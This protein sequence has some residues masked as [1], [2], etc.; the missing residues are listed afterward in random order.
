MSKTMKRLFLSLI[1]VVFALALALGACGGGKP[2]LTFETGDGTP[3]EPIVAE[4][5][6]D[7]TALLPPD[8]TCDGFV[9]D[10]W[11]LDA[12]CT[13]ATDLPTT[14]PEKSTKYYAKWRDASLKQLTVSVGNG[15]TTEGE[16]SYY[17]AAGSNL[18]TFL[19]DKQ[20]TPKTGLE[21]AG[22]YIG[23]TAVTQET[24]MPSTTTTVTA[25]YNATYSLNVYE[26]KADGT[27]PAESVTSEGKGIYGEP[28][29]YAAPEH[30]TLDQTQGTFASDSLGTK[31]SFTVYLARETYLVIYNVNIPESTAHIAS[32]TVYYEGSVTLADG[33]DFNLPNN[34]YFLGWA[35]TAEGNVT[36][37]AG[38]QITNVTDDIRL[39][40]VWNVG[41]A[42]LFGGDDVIFLDGDTVTLHRGGETFTG[43]YNAETSL[44]EVTVGKATLKGK[45]VGDEMFLYYREANEDTFY[46][47]SS[48]Y[49][50]ENPDTFVDEKTTLTLDGYYGA[51]YTITTTGDDGTEKPISLQGVF[52]F[53]GEAGVYT[54][55]TEL[56]GQ[57]VGF[58]FMI[59]DYDPDGD[60]ADQTPVFIQ[61]GSERGTYG[62]FEFTDKDGRGRLGGYVL[63]LD[64]FGGFTL[65]EEESNTAIT[66]RYALT[67]SAGNGA[68]QVG[69]LYASSKDGSYTFLA[70]FHTLPLSGGSQGFILR[71]ETLYHGGE[72]FEL[73]DGATVTLDGFGTFT[74]SATYTKGDE[75]IQG[76]YILKTSDLLGTIIEI[77]GTDGE[78]L[79]A[80]R[81]VNGGSGITLEI[82]DELFTE[83][84]WI[85]LNQES[86]PSPSLYYPM[87]LLYD[88]EVTVDGVTGAK[89][90]ALY[91]PVEQGGDAVKIADGYYTVRDLGGVMYYTLVA[92][93]P[94]SAVES[95]PFTSVS[96]AVGGVT[97]NA[98]ALNVYYAYEIDGQPNYIVI[99]EEGNASNYFWYNPLGI[100]YM[101]TLFFNG[102]LVTEG[103]L[104]SS[105]FDL[106]EGDNVSYWVFD[107]IDIA[108]QKLSSLYIKVTVGQTAG[109]YVL[110]DEQ[111]NTYQSQNGYDQMLLDGAGSA[112]YGVY[113]GE[114]EQWNW[115]DGTYAKSGTTAFG[116]TKYTFT[117]TAGGATVNFIAYTE[118]SAFGPIYYFSVYDEDYD[119]TLQA[120]SGATL[121]LDGYF[122]YGRY[123]TA[124]GE[125]YEGTYTLAY[126]GSLNLADYVGYSFSYYFEFDLEAGSFTEPEKLQTLYGV[127]DDSYQDVDGFEGYYVELLEDGVA[128]L[129]EDDGE[130][131][132]ATG[133]YTLTDEENIYLLTF[134]VEGQ[135]QPLEWKAKIF[136]DDGYPVCVLVNEGIAGK[137]QAP[138]GSMAY[139]DGFGYGWY[140]DKLGF[141]TTAYYNAVDGTHLVLGT[142][143]KNFFVTYDKTKHTFDYVTS[144]VDVI[145]YSDSLFSVEFRDN[146]YY[147]NGADGTT[148]G[149]FE[150]GEGDALTI[151]MRDAN[152]GYTKTTHQALGETYE[153]DQVTYYR[154]TA[155]TA[156]TLTGK[157]IAGEET[158]E[159]YTMT[160]TPDGTYEINGV[161]TLKD[162]K[163]EEVEGPWLIYYGNDSE[164]TIGVVVLVY[165]YSSADMFDVTLHCN[166]TEKNGTF[167]IK[168]AIY[169]NEYEDY[170]YSGWLMLNA[171]YMLG[172]KEL[173]DV[174]YQ[175]EADEEAAYYGD[176]YPCDTQGNPLKI[177]GTELN[178]DEE[179]ADEKLG[180][181]YS[182]EGEAADGV[183]YEIEF[184]LVTEGGE[185]Y[186]LL[187]M[188]TA[189]Q[190]YTVAEGNYL[191]CASFYWFAN[192]FESVFTAQGYKQGDPISFGLYDNSDPENPQYLRPIYAQFNETEIMWFTQ[193]ADEDGN[194]AYK[195]TFTPGEDKIPSAATVAKA[196]TASFDIL[197]LMGHSTVGYILKSEQG[198]TV[199]FSYLG[200]AQGHPVTFTAKADSVTEVG[201]NTNGTIKSVKGTVDE[202]VCSVWYI[203]SEGANAF[204]LFSI[205]REETISDDDGKNYDLTA[206]LSVY[207]NFYNIPS[208]EVID[209][210]IA[211]EGKKIDCG[212]QWFDMD[213]RIVFYY[214]PEGETLQKALDVTL[215]DTGFTCDDTKYYGTVVS[216]AFEGETFIVLYTKED[217]T[218]IDEFLFKY[219]D[220]YYYDIL[221]GEEK[222]GTWTVTSIDSIVYTFT[223]QDGSFD[224]Q[225]G[226]FSATVESSIT[227]SDVNGNDGTV[228]LYTDQSGK[229]TISVDIPTLVDSASQ[230][231]EVTKQDV[232]TDGTLYYVTVKGTDQIEYTIGLA[233]GYNRERKPVYKLYIVTKPGET[234]TADGVT[235]KTTLYW[236]GD[237]LDV[238]GNPYAQGDIYEFTIEGGDT[239]V[240]YYV[241]PDQQ[242]L[243]AV[244]QVAGAEEGKYS[245]QAY[246]YTLTKGAEGTTAT[247]KKAT[248]KQD[249]YIFGEIDLPYGYSVQALFTTDEKG[250]NQI[251]YILYLFEVSGSDYSMIPAKITKNKEQNADGTWSWTAVTPG[252]ADDYTILVDDREVFDVFNADYTYYLDYAYLQGE[253]EDYNLLLIGTEGDVS[254]IFYSY[255]PQ[256]IPFMFFNIEPDAIGTDKQLGSGYQ[257]LLQNAAQQ[258][259]S[260]IFYIG[261]K[262]EEGKAQN[263]FVLDSLTVVEQYNFR[264]TSSTYTVI[265]FR[266]LYSPYL[267]YGAIY[268]ASIRQNGQSLNLTRIWSSPDDSRLVLNVL[269][270]SGDMF[271]FIMDFTF[272]SED[273]TDVENVT[274]S[275]YNAGLFGSKDGKWGVMFA[276]TYDSE[277]ETV[278][279]IQVYGF[280]AIGEDNMVTFD[281]SAT[282]T[283]NEDG[284]WTITTKTG[285]YTFKMEGTDVV[286]TENE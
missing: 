139:L 202:K 191:A 40:A 194:N 100:R 172:S 67:G 213:G 110:L 206:V 15:A 180:P 136:V 270:S 50:P 171:V 246:V 85:H 35:D 286:V 149:F 68:I 197:Y 124:D 267:E 160:F 185:D 169:G 252:D 13:Q 155:G 103:S 248:D 55:Y 114:Q 127:V 161:A 150:V 45:T 97:T 131:L 28:F 120:E 285:T 221:S 61:I 183:I 262:N 108:A 274:L 82:V 59:G 242:Y 243:V 137:Y 2:K 174:F 73:A 204:I 226:E 143:S 14:M 116:D 258:I 81:T 263:A 75:T 222:E 101:G 26:Q 275:L 192:F 260:V 104:S 228:T 251:E 105:S 80:F 236:A 135:D 34:Y 219:V 39:Y 165:N 102:G 158:F 159:N 279:V 175:F 241:E 210:E 20:P 142:G 153:L 72:P 24:V 167:E 225:A 255:A 238:D 151:W 123:T 199:Y 253:Q 224:D 126:D 53:T 240:M 266:T 163:G 247:L 115:T 8:P 16:T 54:F 29:T 84:L 77:Y 168:A 154:Y 220:G 146:M 284:S 74:N 214:T 265:L 173:S 71:N 203:E 140:I 30:F 90:A 1:G 157:V 18:L 125:T 254:G 3:I 5:G 86:Q 178:I 205:N 273:H 88:S 129:Y 121:E 198:I 280:G 239:Y 106:T 93:N 111:P 201:K 230:K 277:T 19:A 249:Y 216:E 207:S 122:H 232:T 49:D 282:F 152:G 89:K 276:Y 32:A 76:Q 36:H 269:Q 217:T 66:G 87:V 196:G 195:I 31:E 4:A 181:V 96:F 145:Y 256:G 250:V 268:S 21:F 83:Y 42:D 63:V 156:L 212:D 231:L 229:E 57:P 44:F 41:L 272:A 218:K 170:E 43:T 46:L 107:Y 138:D 47:Y 237:A 48:Y 186:M 65:T 271:A 91:A 10:G 184:Y 166:F 164:N 128:K 227:Y 52:Q 134:T 62:Y 56:L 58:D 200:D 70:G 259:F 278:T 23:T 215:T 98:D 187:F 33:A 189:Y 79:I 283:K 37:Q 7:I 244:K 12:G 130:T 235:I 9:F 208:E 223:F 162:E 188:I 38:E 182:F 257:V 177:V 211:H 118:S 64:G 234:I 233:L 117:A 11:Y 92:Q 193:T 112:R 144:D 148:G 133:T 179:N 22:W 281:Q 141:E 60:G 27:W 6:A 51:T 17:V 99:S 176:A 245:Y 261:P 95:L 119:V 69:E 109:T 190:E 264:S 147:I 209:Y 132:H 78:T 94:T 25:K 113:D